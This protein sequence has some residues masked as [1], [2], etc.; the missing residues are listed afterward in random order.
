MW[1]LGI[2]LRSSEMAVH[3]LN[4]WDLSLVPLPTINRIIPGFCSTGHLSQD[5]T[6]LS[7]D[8]TEFHP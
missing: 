4:L 8:S 5:F 3:T 1:V 7:K 2:E 6:V